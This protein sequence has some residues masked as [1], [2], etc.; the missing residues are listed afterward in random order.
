MSRWFELTMYLVGMRTVLFVDEDQLDLTWLGAATFFCAH[1][2]V[3]CP[4]RR[5]R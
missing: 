1:D 3:C 5:W 2:V 4:Q